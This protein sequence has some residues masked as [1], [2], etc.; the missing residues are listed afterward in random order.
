MEVPFP[1]SNN[2]SVT[3]PESSVNES[4]QSEFPKSS[5]DFLTDNLSTL[6]D[7]EILELRKVEQVYYFSPLS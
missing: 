5:Q 7:L 3:M 4:L 1:I 2:E 6:L